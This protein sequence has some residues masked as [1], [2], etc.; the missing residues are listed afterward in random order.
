M[1]LPRR[2]LH[3]TR[4]A[5]RAQV[6][7]ILHLLSQMAKRAPVK[8][9]AKAQQKKQEREALVLS[10]SN[11]FSSAFDCRKDEKK[12]RHHPKKGVKEKNKNNTSTV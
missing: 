10:N 9:R 7:Q 11:D 2:G 5:E 8:H 4:V 1:M 3:K 12:T 6:E